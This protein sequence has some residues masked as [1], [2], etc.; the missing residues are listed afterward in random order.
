MKGKWATGPVLLGRKKKQEIVRE[1]GEYSDSEVNEVLD[2]EL[3]GLSFQLLLQ[4]DKELTV[5]DLLDFPTP[6][7]RKFGR[8]THGSTPVEPSSYASVMVELVPDSAIPIEYTEGV[9][10]RPFVQ[11]E[12]KEMMRNR[13]KIQAIKFL[14]D[15]N[16]NLGLREAKQLYENIERKWF[17]QG[18]GQN[19]G[20]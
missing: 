2:E 9:L 4:T 14:R 15:N 1:E 13:K 7:G 16:K 18:K 20:R 10:L 19:H 3:V 11:R 12:L 17:P 8:I 5:G 6:W